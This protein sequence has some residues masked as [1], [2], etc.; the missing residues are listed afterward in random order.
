VQ[1]EIFKALINATGR[2]RERGE[3]DEAESTESQ[4]R[5]PAA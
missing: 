4:Q 3:A 2:G 5:P 1:D